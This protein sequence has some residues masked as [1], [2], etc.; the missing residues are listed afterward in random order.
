MVLGM[1]VGDTAKGSSVA[2]AVL[3]LSA[4]GSASSS[5]SFPWYSSGA[6]LP[7][8]PFAMKLHSH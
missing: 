2:K 8:S 4:Y 5:P 6:A 7:L 1:I 3:P